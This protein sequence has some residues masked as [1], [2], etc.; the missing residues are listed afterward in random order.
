MLSMYFNKN[1]LVAKHAGAA[2][3]NHLITIKC[4]VMMC[5]SKVTQRF[6]YSVLFQGNRC[7]YSVN[8]DNIVEY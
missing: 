2:F 8:F 4:S 6:L 3:I 5:N 1:E 7:E